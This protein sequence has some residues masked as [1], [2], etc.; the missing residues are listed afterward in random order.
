MKKFIEW[1]KKHIARMQD[2]FG[3]TNYGFMWVSFFK[4][5]VVVLIL[6]ALVG[7]SIPNKYDPTTTAI[8]QFFRALGSGDVKKIKELGK[9]SNKEQEEKEWAEVE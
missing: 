5:V 6:V 9:E 8:G 1:H 7:C 3:M 2:A 4:G